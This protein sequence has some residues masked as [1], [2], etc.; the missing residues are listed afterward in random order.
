[1]ASLLL[2]NS[3]FLHLPK[4]AGT[5][6]T[7]AIANCGID[8]EM[9]YDNSAHA[10]Y[11]IV[12]RPDL[13]SIVCVR[14]PISWY[15]SYW[16]FKMGRGWDEHN[17]FDR[18]FHSDE[19]PEFIEKIIQSKRARYTEYLHE[20]TGENTIAFA[21]E[22]LRN[23]IVRSL[24]EC[25]EVFNEGPFYN[26]P[27][28]NPSN[29]EF[30]TKAV[31]EPGQVERLYEL[32]SYAVKYH[33]ELVNS[34]QRNRESPPAKKYWEPLHPFPEWIG[35]VISAHNRPDLIT[36][37]IES[38]LG[39]TVKPLKIV[40][41][42]NSDNDDTEELVKQKYGNHPLVDYI[43]VTRMPNTEVHPPA[44]TRN[45]GYRY[46]FKNLDY[47]GKKLFYVSS[48]DDDD[49]IPPNYLEELLKVMQSDLRLG[50]VYPHMIDFGERKQDCKPPYGVEYDGDRLGNANYIHSGSL[51]R[52]DCLKQIG[53]TPHTKKGVYED[54]SMFRR[55]RSFGWEMKLADVEY[56]HR[57]H[58]PSVQG[59][60]SK[61]KSIKLHNMD[62]S[63]E[64][65]TIAIPFSG[66][67]YCLDRLLDSLKN[68]DYPLEKVNFLFLDNS[69]NPNFGKK[70]KRWLVDSGSNDFRYMKH[71]VSPVFFDDDNQRRIGSID[72]NDHVAGI[73]NRI[74]QQVTTDLIW[75]LE[76]DVI[77]PKNCLRKII[78]KF[79]YD[80]DAIC[81][82]YPGRYGNWNVWEYH[83]WDTGPAIYEYETRL[84]RGLRQVG[85]CGFGC[86]VLRT[87]FM[88]DW[89]L[90]SISRGLRW[91]DP[92]FWLYMYR[93]HA[94]VYCDWTQV[95]DHVCFEE[96][97]GPKTLNKNLLVNPRFE[98]VS[99]SRYN[100]ENNYSKF[101]P[102]IFGF[103]KKK[104]KQN[105]KIIVNKDVLKRTGKMITIED[106]DVFFQK[107]NSKIRVL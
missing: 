101:D 93:R 59:G 55:I 80:I 3:R 74:S 100:P 87:K 97:Y 64:F 47:Q 49:Y 53:M 30:V 82:P 72:V 11:N 8:Y 61:A 99:Y 106:E 37:A 84:T 4:C 29:Y 96:E 88:R 44:F 94:N 57:A 38:C 86:V 19:F 10:G 20:F 83:K 75:C 85:G 42:D 25:G 1:M 17:A 90:Q 56:F 2:P 45:E 28:S 79:R 21:Y 81:V 27:I 12:P 13:P 14:E 22:D 58:P 91:Y 50:V 69:R 43:R 67:T 33:S 89:P 36:M 23:G 70:L 76:D 26:R 51:I 32:E 73:W 66:K 24:K 102:S 107:E 15:R 9:I 31:Y 39:Q 65:L 98:R 7:E 92:L 60:E 95:A 54:W 103:K 77:P 41:S 40:V 48:V 52:V 63:F 71:E 34:I 46:L 5:W 105:S 35:M 104:S 78:S 6:I 68:Q 62:Q 16:S 18:K